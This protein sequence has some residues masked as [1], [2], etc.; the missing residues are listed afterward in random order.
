[1]DM[2]KVLFLIL[3]FMGI[4]GQSQEDIY[5]FSF[6]TIDGKTQA[7]EAFKGKKMLIVNTASECGF[8]RQYEGLQ[9]LH[10]EYGDDL[11]IIGFPANNYGG[12]E[13]GNEG[14]IASFCKKNYGVTFLMASKVSVNGADI[15]PIFKWLCA[16]KNESF[17]GAINW[18]FEK[19][20]ID[21]KGKV[22]ARYR[23]AVEPMSEEILNKI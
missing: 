13:P 14:E 6:E 22:A 20:L 10:K 8:T 1:M 15:H 9:E 11:V 17:T 21:E 5:G 18:N 7:F 3:V 12:Q 16:Q 2:K 4:N 23:S 19:F